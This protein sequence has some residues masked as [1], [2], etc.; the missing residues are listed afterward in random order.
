MAIN[1][2]ERAFT[3]FTKR[4]ILR[5]AVFFFKMPLLTARMISDSAVL[6][7]AEASSALPAVMLSSALRTKVRMRVRL[8]L[9]TSVRASSLRTDF[10]AEA[11]FAIINVSVYR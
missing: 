9:F 1:H 2:A 11:V 4:E 10:F 7:A 5:E 6:I 3:R 8:D